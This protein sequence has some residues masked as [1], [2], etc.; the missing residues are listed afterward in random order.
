[1]PVRMDGAGASTSTFRELTSV[2]HHARWANAGRIGGVA[3]GMLLL[4][5]PDVPLLLP[6]DEV[7]DR[8]SRFV[9][10]LT[11][12][13]IGVIL[14]LGFV[15]CLGVG[16]QWGGISKGWSDGGVVIVSLVYSA[17]SATDG[18]QTLVLAAVSF[19]ALIGWSLYLGPKA[20]IPMSLFKSR[21]FR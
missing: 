1:M 6:F 9:R 7:P 21:H 2:D 16:L 5:L 18:R 20:M 11:L 19:L 17:R 15:T 14:T 12:D 8:R 10:L 3:L 13:W 4:T